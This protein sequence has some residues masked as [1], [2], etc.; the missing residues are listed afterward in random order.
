MAQE[1][2][3]SNLKLDASFWAGPQEQALYSQLCTVDE[4]PKPPEEGF[5][6]RSNSYISDATDSSDCF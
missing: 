2:V 5:Y 1:H 4:Y 3:R 6:L